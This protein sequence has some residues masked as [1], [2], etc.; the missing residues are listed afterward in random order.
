ML[1]PLLNSTVNGQICR[2]YYKTKDCIEFQRKDFYLMGQSRS[3]VLEI[4]TSSQFEL[5]LTG[6]RDYIV[7][8]CTE[9]VYYPVNFK[10][11]S[12]DGADLIYDNMHDEYINSIGFTIDNTQTVVIEVVLLAEGFKATDFNDNRACV[13]V[14][15]QFKKT[16]KLGF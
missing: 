1:F 12:K 5:V 13:G 9:K 8:C 11:I 7:T 6:G 10:I 16:P 3:A 2:K 4:G 15:I 14:S